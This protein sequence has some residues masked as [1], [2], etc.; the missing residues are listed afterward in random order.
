LNDAVFSEVSEAARAFSFIL[1]S[2][3]VTVSPA[4][5]ATSMVDWPRC[6]ESFTAFS[7]LAVARLVLGHRPDRAVVLGGADLLAGVDALLRDLKFAVG[8]VQVLQGDH[9]A[10]VR[11][12]AIQ[13]HFGDFPIQGCRRHF[14]GREHFA[15][16]QCPRSCFR[17]CKSVAAI[18][19]AWIMSR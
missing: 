3:S 9:R 6:S 13:S 19:A 1:P 14:D 18:F 11:V 10:R 4:A 17:Y 16:R 5:R 2:R 7:E 8:G 15:H 12:D